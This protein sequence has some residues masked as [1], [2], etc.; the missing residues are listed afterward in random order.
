MPG[1]VAVFDNNLRPLSVNR[2][3]KE[4]FGLHEEAEDFCYKLLKQ[5]D[6]P[7]ETCPV[8]QTFEDGKS[9]QSEMEYVKQNGEAFNVL[10]WSTPLK[11]HAGSVSN[12]MVMSTD[13]THVLNLQDHLSSLGL[14]IGS[15]S[16]GIKGLLTGLD[17]GVYMLD[18][19]FSKE[20]PDKIQE[21][22]DIVKLMV[23]RI[24]NMVLDILYYAKEREPNLEKMKISDFSQ[25]LVRIVQGKIQNKSLHFQYDF[26][27]KLENVSFTVDVDQLQ[28]AL[29]NILENAVDACTENGVKAQHHIDFSVKPEADRILF[30]IGDDGTGMDDATREKIFTL[31]FSSKANKGTG[32]GL[33]VAQKIVKQHK[34]EISVESEKG[35]G[36]QFFVRIP[37][38]LQIEA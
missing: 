11:D 4:D 32:I 35:K 31:F 3:F 12:V 9:H 34:G 13:I 37:R 10:A 29:V 25:E 7:C 24:K 1:Y 23:G 33:F 8:L 5:A 18:S 15:V 2:Q 19:G 36:S 21:G 17:G 14:M 20:D 22:L 38:N 27:K 28:S 6:T 26:D 16:H 30:R